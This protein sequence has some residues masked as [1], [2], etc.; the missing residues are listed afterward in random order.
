MS[1]PDLW[2]DPD[3]ARRVTSEFSSVNDD[4]DLL[5]DLERQLSDAE[6]LHELMVEEADDS[7]AR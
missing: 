6:V 3:E 7:V 2:D 1:R 5:E 4:I